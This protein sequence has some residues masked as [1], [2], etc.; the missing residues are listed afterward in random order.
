MELQCRVV[1]GT[2]VEVVGVQAVHRLQLLAGVFV[3][4]PACT[5]SKQSAIGVIVVL[6]DDKRG[7]CGCI[8]AIMADAGGS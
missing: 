6:L 7:C 1:V 2:G 3:A 8:V 5:L 4:L